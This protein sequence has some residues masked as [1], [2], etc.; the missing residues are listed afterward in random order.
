M[1]K[2]LLFSDLHLHNWTYGA[3][4]ERGWN[5]RLLVQKRFLEDIR[6]VVAQ[7]NIDHVFFLGDL[8]H[9][10]GILRADVIEVAYN[11]FKNIAQSALGMCVSLVGNHDFLTRNGGIHSLSFMEG[12]GWKIAF[13]EF[14]FDNFHFLSFMPDKKLFYDILNMSNGKDFM[15]FH[16]GVLGVPMSSGFELPDEVLR[17]TSLPKNSLCFTGHYHRRQKVADNLVIVG[18]PIQHTWGDSGDDRGYIILDTETKEYKFYNYTAAPKFV[19]LEVNSNYDIDLTQVDN[20]YVRLYGDVLP[21][22]LENARDM[23]IDNG[24][25]SCELV[26]ITKPAPDFKPN[27]IL[28]LTDAIKRYE[29]EMSLSKKEIETGK[30]IRDRKYGPK[31]T[32]H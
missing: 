8:F 1:S 24:A 26:P 3:T 16:Q 25:R 17:V 22:I 29:E 4:Q 31:K 15:F 23:V 6:D 32:L 10:H 21:T 18:S 9:E 28:S 5:S 20:N 13:P 11:G 7:Q 12:T 14:T 19:N 30:L 27:K 2:V